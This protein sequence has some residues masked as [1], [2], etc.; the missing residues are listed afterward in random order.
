MEQFNLS[1]ICRSHGAGWAGISEC[2]IRPGEIRF[3]VV[4][5]NFT[6]K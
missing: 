1:I 2:G 3:A 5:T 4:C 6:G